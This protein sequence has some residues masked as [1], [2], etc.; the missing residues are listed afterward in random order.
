M[1]PPCLSWGG[2][3]GCRRHACSPPPSTSIVARRGCWSVASGPAG[4]GHRIALGWDAHGQDAPGRDA[5]GRDAPRFAGAGL[6]GCW[7][8]GAGAT[9]RGC[10]VDH[11]MSRVR[12]DRPGEYR[13]CPPD[14]LAA[15]TREYA[16]QRRR[17]TPRPLTTSSSASWK[18]CPTARRRHRRRPSPWSPDRTHDV[19]PG[20]PRPRARARSVDT[21]GP[22][23]AIGRHPSAQSAPGRRPIAGGT[24]RRRAAR[25]SWVLFSWWR[26]RPCR[27]RCRAPASRTRQPRHRCRCCS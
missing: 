1:P 12:R 16:C 4:P 19:V 26:S 24:P 8:R 23:H 15:L 27:R 14:P 3:V 2:G 21:R 25:G 18:R 10:V 7:V 13:R 5:P 17:R 11:T 22:R 6:G 20:R 9:A